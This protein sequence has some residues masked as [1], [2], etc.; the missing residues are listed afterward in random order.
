M[1]QLFNLERYIG[2]VSG[3]TLAAWLRAAD[4][5]ST[6]MHGDTVTAWTDRMGL[7]T[8]V[9]GS[10][11]YSDGSESN[12]PMPGVVVTA[13]TD[14]IEHDAVAGIHSAEQIIV[15]V[16]RLNN[17]PRSLS[18]FNQYLFNLV[19]TNAATAAIRVDSGGQIVVNYRLSA[20]PGTAQEEDVNQTAPQNQVRVFV[21]RKTATTIELWINQQ[22]V[23]S[24][25]DTGDLDTAVSGLM[26][27]GN[28]P[29][30]DSP[31]RQTLHELAIINGEMTN[32]ELR[33]MIR[34]LMASY[35]DQCAVV[36]GKRV[37]AASDLVVTGETIT[38]VRGPA[39]AIR[40]GVRHLFCCPAAGGDE[41][42]VLHATASIDDPD[43]WTFDGLEVIAG[44][45]RDPA[46]VGVWHDTT[47]DR[48]V[49]VYDDQTTGNLYTTTLDATN[50]ETVVTAEAAV[51]SADATYAYR[52]TC[53]LQ[54]GDRVRLYVDRRTTGAHAGSPVTSGH[55]DIVAYDFAASAGVP[56]SGNITALN[57]GNALL[58]NSDTDWHWNGD[59]IGRPDVIYSGGLFWMLADGF[60]YDSNPNNT[61]PHSIGLFVST[62]GITNWRSP[63][64]DNPVLTYWHDSLQNELVSD[65][66][67][68]VWRNDFPCFYYHGAPELQEGDIFVARVK[69]WLAPI[70]LRGGLSRA[71]RIETVAA[72][73]LTL[74]ELQADDGYTQ[75]LSDSLDA[76]GAAEA[77]Q[78]KL[79]VS[80]NIASTLD[81]TV[82]AEDIADKRTFK[83]PEN[84]SE[85]DATNF[86][87][88]VASQAGP[89]TVCFRVGDVLEENVVVAS[90][91]SATIS[92]S[93]ATVGT[94]ALHT[95]R[96]KVNVPLTSITATPGNYTVTLTF[97]ATDTEQ[98]VVRGTLQVA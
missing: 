44:S 43:N 88:A 33:E 9:E 95:S 85:I 86:V 82:T 20:S 32:T 48:W 79:P 22:Q 17:S 16:G 87:D 11:Y 28:H 19:S 73:A 53:L 55:G 71:G 63:I 59:D 89:V 26:C 34:G 7:D 46:G 45:A 94:P 70:E 80:G 13:N 37:V 97:V 74:T 29:T 23:V 75:L 72:G 56:T 77:V 21:F 14:R 92:G 98:Y 4:L 81:G 84:G 65:A 3:A 64:A 1:S 90:I 47:N 93:G 78:N 35:V 57:S 18:S 49:L 68:D 83:F 66:C 69:D 51:L 62:D 6:H 15:W 41:L 54:V 30:T 58:T 42:G 10:P 25:S 40:N 67:W 5:D 96:R 24:A 39:I 38:Q 50:L 8:T 12:C 2:D 61:Y 27:W 60:T 76:K 91:T 52:H 31:T 36:P